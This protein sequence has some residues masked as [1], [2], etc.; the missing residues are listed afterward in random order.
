MMC[1]RTGRPPT[2]TSGFGRYSVSS[3]MRVP[4]PPQR[5][6][7]FT[8]IPSLV[9]A[10][11]RFHVGPPFAWPPRRP[12]NLDRFHDVPPLAHARGGGERGHASGVLFGRP[13]VLEVAEQ[14]IVLEEDRPV[15]EAGGAN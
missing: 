4:W 5:M 1:Q 10:E 7:T 8:I 9:E 12:R 13:G 11:H 2:S 3:R 6:T 14:Q 15:D